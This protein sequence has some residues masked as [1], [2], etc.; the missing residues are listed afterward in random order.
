MG[1]SAEAVRGRIRRGT[2]P[3]ERENGAVYVLLDYPVDDRTTGDQ[4]RTNTGRPTDRPQSE[5]SALISEL[6]AHNATLQAQ[7][8]SERQALEA[9]RDAHAESR[10]L[11]LQALQKIPDAIEPPQEPP[12]EPQEAP[13]TA[14]EGSGRVGAQPSLE[15]RQRAPQ[16]PHWREE[17][18]DTL[19]EIPGILRDA[20]GAWRRFLQR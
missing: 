6:R 14:R 11:L 1:I 19:R 12:Q 16:R 9:E 18:Q 2:L 17:A 5:P 15:E 8:A 20:R 3:V 7:L 10:R 4:P 13:Q